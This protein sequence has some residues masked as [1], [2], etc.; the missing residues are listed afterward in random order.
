MVSCRQ[1]SRPAF[2]F[3][4]LSSSILLVSLHFSDDTMPFIFD[5]LTSCI[6]TGRAHMLSKEEVY[7][8]ALADG[9]NKVIF[10]LGSI[11]AVDM[12]TDEA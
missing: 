1:L 7:F 6:Q 2:R 9:Q 10:L 4:F 5:I 11:G 12:H 3:Y 8:A